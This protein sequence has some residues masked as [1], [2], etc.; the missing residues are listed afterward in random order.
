MQERSNMAFCALQTIVGATA[1]V[2]IGWIY[3]ALILARMEGRHGILRALAATAL[4]LL[5][6]VTAAVAIWSVLGLYIVKIWRGGA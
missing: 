5:G 3:P 2:F 4:I 1:A 6:L